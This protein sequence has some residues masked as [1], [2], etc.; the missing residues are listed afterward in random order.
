VLVVDDEPLARARLVRML[1]RIEGV[2]LAGEAEDGEQALERAAALAPDVI[3]L[4]IDMPG[5]DGL[6][7]AET[8]GLPPIVFT[9]GHPGYA[10]DAFDVEA[11][12]YLL[13][14]ITE[15]RLERALRKVEAR[16]SAPAAAS[17]PWRLVVADGSLRV[18][19]DAREVTCFSADQKYVAFRWRERELLLRESLDALALR[20]A[21]YGF[22]RANRAA[23][24]R[25]DAVVAF[26]GA[27]GGTLVLSDDQRI[28][29]SRRALASVREALGVD[30]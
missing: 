24:V 2:E 20:L 29:V 25:R 6:A 4:D 26:D 27:D 5:L 15:E 8:E 11:A 17:E 16:R 23:L 3:L 19:V 21:P 22:L 13:K 18:F 30:R 1:A 9:T 7:V 10:V 28:P 12:D 14:P